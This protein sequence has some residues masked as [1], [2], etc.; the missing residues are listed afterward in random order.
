MPRFAANLTMLWPELDVYDRFRA[1]AEA[2]FRR[3]EI[4]FVHSLDAT[5][6][7][8]T[9]RELGLELVLFDPAPG[10]WA[11][12]ERGLLSVPGREQEFLATVREAVTAARR[13]GTRLLNALAG[14]PPADIS[15]AE[16]ERT[17]IANL[18]A[19]VPLAEEAGVTLLV[20]AINSIDMPGYFADTVERAAAL[21]EGAGS[22]SVRLQLDQYHVGMAGADARAALRRYASL[23]AHVQIADVP[24]R[25]QPGTGTQPIREF[26][27]DLDESGYRGSVGLEYRPRGSMD[28]ALAWLPRAERG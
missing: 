12:G 1:A 5:R 4:L 24:G 17:A 19:A 20:E 9:L 27:R 18:R 21:V 25:N 6:V 26:L 11:R 22:P 8:K 28:D 14:I 3:V 16:G 23:V 2:G 13:F 15:R 10:D 7:E